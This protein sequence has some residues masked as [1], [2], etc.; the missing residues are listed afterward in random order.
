MGCY[1][2]FEHADAFVLWGSNMAEM[3][4][5]LW[6]RVTDR[7]PQRPHVQIATLSTYEHR[8]TDLSDVRDHLQARHRPRDP[9]LHRQPHHPDRRGEPRLRRQALSTSAWPTPTSATA[10]G[11]STCWSSGPSTPT[12]RRSRSPS[13]FDAYAKL[14]SRIHARHGVRALRRAEDAAGSAGEALRRPE[15]QGDVALDHGVQPARPRRLGQPPGLQPPPADREDLGA[16]QQPVLAHRPALGLRHGARGRHLLP[17]PARRHAGRPIPSTAS[18]RRSIWKLPAGL[19]PDKVGY[20]AVQQDR[21]LKDGKLNAYW[22]MCNNNLQTAPNTNNETYP[23]YRNPAELRRG[24]RSLS[25][26]HRHGG[27]PHPADRDVGREG[28]RLRQRRAAHPFLAPAR[29]RARRGP[30]RPVAVHG[31]LEALHDR[32]GLAGGHPRQGARVP[33]QDAVRRAV[34]QRP[35]RT[36]SRSP[37]LDPGYENH[38]AKAFG[39]YVQKGLFE[40]YATFGRGHGHDL[41]PFDTYHQVRGLRWPVVD[42]KETLLALPRGP[43]PLRREGQRA[44]VLRQPRQE[45]E[46]HRAR[47]TSRRPRSPDQEFDLW[48]VTGRVL[49]HW[50]SGSM[51]LRVPELYRAFPGA[52][53]FMHPDDAHEA[54][55]APRP[56][57]ADRLAARRD[58]HAASRR[59]GATR[60][61]RAWS[62]CRSST[63]ASSSTR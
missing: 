2:D 52:V 6:T 41:A 50:H 10:C 24:L 20:H 15:D 45:G 40:E 48:L 36:S 12:T 25:D 58:P 57:G 28:R 55:A 18:T 16:G 23:G 13:D 31:V 63:R 1:D 5:I 3:H 53:L 43:R 17:P 56:G 27:R 54:R 33:G 60:C 35:G 47:P 39:F 4:P 61:R 7:R 42:G 59:A 8:T 21:M 29:R 32:R 11:R 62:S 14:V 49:E 38:E 19:L 51:T 9:E 26:R 34:T 22:I 46:P 30:L 44:P 37:R